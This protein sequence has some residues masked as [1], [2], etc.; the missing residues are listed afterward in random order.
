VQKVFPLG[1][2][3]GGIFVFVDE[4][5]KSSQSS[6][7]FSFFLFWSWENGRAVSSIHRERAQRSISKRAVTSAAASES[8][9]YSIS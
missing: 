6:K 3:L 7:E 2:Y 4:N 9:G 1:Q 8:D 5:H